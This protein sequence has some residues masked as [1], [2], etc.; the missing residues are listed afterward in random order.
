M[1]LLLQ[2]KDSLSFRLKNGPSVTKEGQFAISTHWIVHF[3]PSMHISSNTSPEV[4]TDPV[5]ISI[6]F[7]LLWVQRSIPQQCWKFITVSWAQS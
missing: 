4:P 1:A 7:C 6:L 5:L 3:D 2:K